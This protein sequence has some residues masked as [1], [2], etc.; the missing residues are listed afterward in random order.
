MPRIIIICIVISTVFSCR[1]H[2]N[3]PIQSHL[4]ENPHDCFFPSLEGEVILGAGQRYQYK[5][6][7]FNPNNPDEFVFFEEDLDNS[8][9]AHR[10]SKF[11]IATKEKTLLLESV[12]IHSYMAW[13]KQGEIAFLP[14]GNQGLWLMDENGG[15]LSFVAHNVSSFSQFWSE[16]GLHIYWC[17]SN[18]S[19]QNRYLLRKH[20]PDFNIDTIMLFND[21]S[22]DARRINPSWNAVNTTMHNNYL[23]F[24]QTTVDVNNPE[25]VVNFIPF[26]QVYGT[27]GAFSPFCWHPDGQSF[28]VQFGN[29]FSNAI[30]SFTSGIYRIYLDGSSTLLTEICGSKYY[31]S[32]SCS[33]D[34]KYLIGERVDTSR[35]NINFK[36]INSH[37]VLIEIATG[38]ETMIEIE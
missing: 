18:S 1:K 14:S 29:P 30:Q 8:V 24:A 34:G 21:F 10:I 38:I 22:W 36:Y 31:E 26:A 19:N 35:E 27:F 20:L 33:P 15:N 16:D 23:H 25:S 9:N 13:G 7:S 2:E 3:P 37:I 6:P 32:I 5:W 17:I 28:F 12:K 4:V 11:K